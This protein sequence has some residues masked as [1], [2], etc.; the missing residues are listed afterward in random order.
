M[1]SIRLHVDTGEMHSS[2]VKA[3]ENQDIEIEITDLEVC[4]YVFNGIAFERLTFDDLLRSVFED[5]KLLTRIKNLAD[6]F[7]R[8]I[9]IIEGE[10]PFLAGRTINPGSIQSFLRKIA[11]SFRVPAVFTLDEVETAELIL[12]IT[13]AENSDRCNI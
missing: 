8:P 4:D 3:L 6:H 1:S 2:V 10:D 11:T 9:L 7:E 5:V 13:G 12:S